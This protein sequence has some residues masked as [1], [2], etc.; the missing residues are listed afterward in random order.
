MEELRKKDIFERLKDEFNS[1]IKKF[2]SINDCT[3]E[4]R[5]GE[6]I[7]FLNAMNVIGCISFGEYCELFV[8]I[9]R[10]YLDKKEIY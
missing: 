4:Y 10:I 9:N 8:K 6:I 3:L 1:N 2:E 5:F 7:G